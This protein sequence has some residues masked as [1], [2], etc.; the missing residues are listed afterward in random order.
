MESQFK[1]ALEE[2]RY[3][4]EKVPFFRRHMES[5]AL[6]PEDIV[7]PS[8]LRRIPPTSKVQYRV[9]FP[10]GVLAKG[11]TL[12]EPFS[13]RAQSSGTED[14]RLVTLCHFAT[15]T[16]RMADCLTVNPPLDR[17]LMRPRKLRSCSYAAPNCSDVDCANP[18]SM[19]KD[20]IL[21]DGTL[22]LPVH[23]DLLTTP[24]RLIE[25]AAAEIAEHQPEYF[26]CDP[27]HL[28]FLAR[29]LARRS[30]PPPPCQAISLTYNLLTRVSRRQISSYWKGVEVSSIIAMT[31]FGWLGI[32]CPRGQLHMNVRSYYLEFLV[33]DR[34]AEPGEIADLYVTSLGDTLSPHIRYHTRDH[35][36]LTGEPC[37]CGHPYPVAR[38][39]GRARDTL[40]HAGAVLLTPRQLDQI[41]GEPDWLDIYQL[42]QVG[43]RQYSFR[44]IGNDAFEEPLAAALKERLEQ[45]LGPGAELHMEGARYLP[46]ERSGKLLSCVARGR[47]QV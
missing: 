22:I 37:A 25:K 12:K 32:T 24:D 15:L 36:S 2:V 21:P 26:Y 6:S 9:N 34:P 11:K 19:M 40:R 35:Y 44:Y 8:D 31:E 7:E 20:R 5:A 16:R 30:V 28:A 39:E 46:A 38:F 23:H 14:E 29:A 27:T 18:S 3:A 1:K 13:N 17:F 47:E 41:V 33:G 4:H 43:E 45:A 10:V 42:R